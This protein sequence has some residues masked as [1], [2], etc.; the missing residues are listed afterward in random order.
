MYS[1]PSTI[2]IYGI[3]I[4]TFGLFLLMGLLLMAFVVWSEGKKDGFSEERLFDLMLVSLVSSVLF[5]RIGFA[6]NHVVSFKDFITHVYKIWTPGFSYLG[7]LI[8]FIIP[9]LILPRIWKWSVYRL[10]D[11][12]ALA[13]SLAFSVIVLAAV[14]MQ[15]KFEYL[16]AFAS[17]ILL[18]AVLSK[19]RSIKVKSG[20]VFSLFLLLNAVLAKLFFKESPRVARQPPKKLN[21]PPPPP[22][23][24]SAD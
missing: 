6:F 18:F 17:W 8:G 3:E 24:I 21:S 5:S 1:V 9:M 20:V 2:I 4:H 14:G 12:F 16:F 11:I 13:F 10:L 22:E 7:G 23:R 19:L 15:S